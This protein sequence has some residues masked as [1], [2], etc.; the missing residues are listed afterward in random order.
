M[1]SPSVPVSRAMAT[2]KQINRRNATKK[3][4]RGQTGLKK[5]AEKNSECRT[6]SF[7]LISKGGRGR[8]TQLKNMTN[9]DGYEKLRR[10]C[11]K[12]TSLFE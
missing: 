4:Q 5:K 12:C 11:R 2:A 1:C 6:L 3:E 10:L 7:A 8:V 9:M